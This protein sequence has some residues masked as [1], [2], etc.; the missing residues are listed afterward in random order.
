M[1][2][3]VDAEVAALLR[4]VADEQPAFRRRLSPTEEARLELIAERLRLLY[5]GI[6][7]ARRNLS[8]SWSEKRLGGGGAYG[9]TYERQAEIAPVVEQLRR[10]HRRRLSMPVDDNGV[11]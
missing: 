6:T 9:K 1:E 7:R 8:I 5:V 4:S 10:F 2:G 3:D 11:G